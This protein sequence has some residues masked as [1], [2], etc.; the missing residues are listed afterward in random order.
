M[1][2]VC[3]QERRLRAVKLGGQLNGIEFLEVVSPQT[4]HVHLVKP[5]VGIQAD[6]VSVEGGERIPEVEVESVAANDHVL[7]VQ[8]AGTGDFSYYTLRIDTA[9]FDPMLREIK[10]TFKVDCDSGFDCRETCKCPAPEGPRPELDYLAKDYASLRRMLLD[11]ISLISPRWRERNPADLG[12]ALVELLAYVGDRLSYRQDAI[13]T[14]AYLETARSRVSLRRHGRLVDYRMHDGCS[15][16]VLLRCGVSGNGVVL[17]P[18]T[19][20]YSKVAG[21][22]DRLNPEQ[23]SAALAAGATVFETVDQAVLYADHE[24]FT[25]YTWGDDD[26]C[27][28]KGSTAATLLGEHPNLK[29]GDILVITEVLGPATGSKADA[30]PAHT[31][32]VRLTSV[33]SSQDPSGGRF[34]PTPTNDPVTVTEISWDDADR[35]PFPVCVS[36]PAAAGKPVSEAWGNIVIADHGRS[37]PVEQVGQ[38]SRLRYGPLTRSVAVN[39]NVLATTES[40][41]AVLAELTA[42]NPSTTLLDWLASHGVVF[43]GK[44]VVVRGGHGDWSV[45]DGETVARVRTNADGDLVITGRPIPASEVTIA[46]PRLA[47]PSI[48]LD[49]G[50]ATWEPKW[51]LLG[52]DASAHEFAV[53]SEHDGTTYLRLN[54]P[55]PGTVFQARYRIGNGVAGNVGARALVHIAAANVDKVSNPMPAT[56]GHEPETAEELRR[57]APEAYL[58]QQRAVTE[59]DWQDVA[60]RDRRVQHAAA[61]WRWTG[62]W[63]TVFLTVDR[64]GGSEVDAAFEASLRAGLERYRLAGYDLEVDGPRYVPLEL[65][66]H[67]CVSEGHLRSA[68]RREVIAALTALFHADRLTFAQPV[69]LSPIYAAAQAV[70]GVT[71]VNVHTFRRRYHPLASGIHSGVLK[72]GRLEIA[73]LDN[74]PNFPE[75]GQLTLTLGGGR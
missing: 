1:R 51:D 10:F 44:T 69:Y 72:M 53:E 9:G 31:W 27:L 35:L 66:L 20:V 32:P 34:L 70:P 16:R 37:V 43:H 63:H 8:T 68:V 50:E 21:L 61:T 5:A 29:A 45:S 2:Y 13:A 55:A 24:A 52:S 40:D 60:T 28:P 41:A 67:V 4:L 75:R 30:D 58:T 36:A 17:A 33:V 73:R 7:V 38:R 18:H 23:E 26:C 25:F 62:S 6:Q 54:N 65:G 22:P 64:K 59:A 11:R 14:E 42:R 57:D 71:S 46:D 12:V 19:R 49:D 74:N 56:G 48:V 39:P 15:A 47:R 3:E